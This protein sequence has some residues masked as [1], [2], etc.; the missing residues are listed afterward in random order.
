MSLNVRSQPGAN[1]P[2][3]PTLQCHALL[4]KRKVVDRANMFLN[5]L[6]PMRNHT[7]SIMFPIVFP[8]N[9]LTIFRQ[10]IPRLIL[11]RV[12]S[13]IQLNERRKIIALVVLF[14]DML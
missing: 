10:R 2:I 7:S 9:Q 12:K 3:S 13:R 5:Q 8:L 6:V 4:R 1:S 11:L 14:S